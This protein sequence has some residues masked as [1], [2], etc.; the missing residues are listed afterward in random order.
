MKTDILGSM[1]T[2]HLNQITQMANL[3]MNLLIFGALKMLFII[4]FSLYAIFAFVTT[5]QIEIMSH[6][7]QTPLS[8]SIRLVGYIHLFVALGMIVYAL[9]FLP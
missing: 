8:S 1:N 9:R 2:D 6:T 5:R 4:G 7:V 3:P